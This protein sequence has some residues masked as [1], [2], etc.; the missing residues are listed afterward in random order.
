MRFFTT[1]DRKRNNAN[2]KVER[3]TKKNSEMVVKMS[4]F[5]DKAIQLLLDEIA[6]ED[7]YD[8]EKSVYKTERVLFLPEQYRGIRNIR[9]QDF[10][11]E[12]WGKNASVPK[13]VCVEI[14]SGVSDLR[15]GCG[16]NFF[17]EYNFLMFEAGHSYWPIKM[18]HLKNLDEDIGILVIIND[19]LFCVRPA[20]NKRL[21]E[22]FKSFFKLDIGETSQ[23]VIEHIVN[24][25]L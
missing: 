19:H 25:T 22:P 4:K 16:L 24:G 7:I 15:S 11:A 18:H 14:K 13:R 23:D 9:R 20:K 12:L 1:T 21:S 17:E 3:R 8:L 6:N 10:Y 5:Q 2:I